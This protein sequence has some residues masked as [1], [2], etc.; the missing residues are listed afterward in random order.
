M[1]LRDYNMRQDVYLFGADSAG[2]GNAIYSIKSA[3]LDGI[4]SEKLKTKHE[5]KELFI[6]CECQ[7]EILKIDKWEDEE[8]YYL[9]V[10]KYSFPN[11]SFLRRIGYAWNVLKG[12]GVR[13]AGLVLSKENFNKIKKFK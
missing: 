8:E 5:K 2:L 9:T 12:E 10:F 7:G 13:A 3:D 4:L 11:I 1:I 6:Q